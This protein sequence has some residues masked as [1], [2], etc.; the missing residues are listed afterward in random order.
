MNASM[1]KRQALILG[2]LVV[3]AIAEVVKVND[4]TLWHQLI[5]VKI[6]W[7]WM[8]GA[9]TTVVAFLLKSDGHPSQAP[10]DTA[11]N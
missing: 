5:D 3:V 6:F 4:L 9:A 7:A 10:A 1:T 11:D 8:S 2:G